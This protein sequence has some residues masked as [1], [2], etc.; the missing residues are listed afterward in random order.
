MQKYGVER[1]DL[2]ALYAYATQRAGGVRKSD[3]EIEHS[4]P[5]YSKLIKK[6]EHTSDRI[7][8][9]VRAYILS[10]PNDH[11]VR[12]KYTITEHLKESTFSYVY[13]VS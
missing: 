12:G 4:A 1:A 10:K 6:I 3:M 8:T 13:L 5:D 9:N 2:P 7:I 11:E